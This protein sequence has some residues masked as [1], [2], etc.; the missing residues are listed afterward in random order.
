MFQGFVSRREAI[1]SFCLIFMEKT[2]CRAIRKAGRTHTIPQ[3]SLRHA[4]SSLLFIFEARSPRA[5]LHGNLG[6]SY[7]C[8]LGV[9][10]TGL[11]ATVASVARTS[12]DNVCSILY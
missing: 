10:L 1:F 3:L 12:F 9:G 2:I 6:H 5:Q 4:V 8:F 11:G 7:F